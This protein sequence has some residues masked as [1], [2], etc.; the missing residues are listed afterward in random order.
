MRPLLNRCHLADSNAF[1][2]S[3]LVGCASGRLEHRVSGALHS[4]T[5]GRPYPQPFEYFKRSSC[6]RQSRYG[7]IELSLTERSLL[8]SSLCTCTCTTSAVPPELVRVFFVVNLICSK[9]DSSC[10]W[11]ASNSYFACK[12]AVVQAPFHGCGNCETD[13]VHRYAWMVPVTAPS[14]PKPASRKIKSPGNLIQ[15]LTHRTLSMA[16]AP[17]HSGTWKS[18]STLPY[19]RCV[20]CSEGEN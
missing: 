19:F 12:C 13:K 9:P 1:L 14:P 7:P 8:C 10:V 3:R 15:L 18:V 20:L 6:G 2:S 17:G 4:H 5:P 11:F 16:Y